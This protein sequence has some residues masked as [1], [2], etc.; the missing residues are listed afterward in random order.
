LKRTLT[1]SFLLVTLISISNAATITLGGPLTG[2]NENPPVNSTATGS[3]S[4]VLDTTAHTLVIDIN[5]SGLTSNTVAAHIHC[6]VA[7]PGNAGVATTVPA[8]PGFTLGSTSGT[9]HGTLNLMDAGSYNPAF[10]TANGGTVASADAVF[11]TGIQ[12]LQTYLNIH[13]V[14]FGGGEVRA[15]LT[16]AASVPEPGT[17]VLAAIGGAALVLAGRLRRRG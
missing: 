17:S 14:N 2:A 6:C 13:T 9:Y 8:F 1:I 3:T 7:A 12:N 10:V 5:Y 4:V 15:F 11:E 16:P